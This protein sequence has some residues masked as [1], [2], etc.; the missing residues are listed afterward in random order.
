MTVTNKTAGDK[1]F[2]EYEVYYYNSQSIQELEQRLEELALED[3]LYK[4]K[5]TLQSSKE[6]EH[7]AGVNYKKYFKL[8]LFSREA[9]ELLTIGAVLSG[10]L[11][12][13]QYKEFTSTTRILLS[14][15]I[16]QGML[17]FL[18]Y[19]YGVPFHQRLIINLLAYPQQSLGWFFNSKH[20]VDFNP[21][22]IRIDPV[23]FKIVI[24][25]IRDQIS[26]VIKEEEAALRRS[27][28]SI[29]LI[30][31]Q[32]A[33]NIVAGLMYGS[34]Q[35]ISYSYSR[36]LKNEI[37][38]YIELQISQNKECDLMYLINF[39]WQERVRAEFSATDKENLYKELLAIV[40][41]PLNQNREQL[42]LLIGY[43]AIHDPR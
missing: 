36:R 41:T 5:D 4:T 21:Q 16:T 12:T 40:D 23:S 6:K 30:A 24:D 39:I 17:N 8:K 20:K 13:K 33:E 1:N 43:V 2:R 34:A 11:Y 37:Q 29:P 9:V 14:K 10:S 42:I 27:I 38:K 7:S 19:N 18:M 35:A 15:A 3:N 31:R 28:D 22:P 25:H 32:S 26:S